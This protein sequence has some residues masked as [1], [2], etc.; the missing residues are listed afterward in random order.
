MPADSSTE[1]AKPADS[2]TVEVRV[3]L[4]KKEWTQWLFCF[5]FVADDW[6]LMALALRMA[7]GAVQDSTEKRDLWSLR[8]MVCLGTAD[9]HGQHRRS[10]SEA[11][12]ILVED[13]WK[14]LEED[15]RSVGHLQTAAECFGVLHHRLGLFCFVC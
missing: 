8:G 6:E 4:S 1:V 14:T 2:S 9:L 7:A 15:G 12:P 10:I 3:E 11:M 13:T 5:R